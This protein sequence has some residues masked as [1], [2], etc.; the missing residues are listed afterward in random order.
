M[1]FGA[2]VLMDFPELTPVAVY[3][4]QAEIRFPYV[5]G[6]LSFRELPVL[7]GI[8]EKMREDFCTNV[9]LVDWKYGK[10]K[11]SLPF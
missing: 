3:H 4:A 6:Y 9:C 11:V 10:Q 2:V 8:F 7:M 5:P 1:L